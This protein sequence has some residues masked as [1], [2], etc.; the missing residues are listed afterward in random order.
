MIGYFGILP[1]VLL[2]F[3]S[4]ECNGESSLDPEDS[5]LHVASNEPHSRQKRF[6]YF[7]TQ[8]PVDIGKEG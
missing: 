3:Y 5:P 7:N 4:V 8:S 1:L 2:G 6:V